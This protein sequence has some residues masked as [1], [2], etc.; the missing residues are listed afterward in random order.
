MTIQEAVNQRAK[1]YAE[2]DKL[3]VEGN[4]LHA[5]GAKLYVEGNK[6]H[7]EGAKLY[8]EG[9]KL[10]AEG[11]K[12]YAEGDK[13]HAEGDLTVCNAV[14]E[15]YGPKA[16]IEWIDNKNIKISKNEPQ[17]LEVKVE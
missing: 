8:V 7:A 3:Y 14:I 12:L 15:V 6:L 10:H 9:D 16:M 4:K 2:G 1:L 5:E 17:V 13:L 11:D